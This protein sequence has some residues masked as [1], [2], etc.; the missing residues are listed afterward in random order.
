MIRVL[1]FDPAGKK[2][3]IAGIQFLADALE[4]SSQKLSLY[5]AHLLEAPESF[6]GSQRTQ[7]MAHASAAIVSLDQP[8]VIVSEEPWGLG[9]SKK[10]L[11]QLIGAIKAETWREIEWQGVSEARRAVIGDSWGGSDKRVTSEWLLEYPW[12]ISSKRIIKKLFDDAN[13]ATDDGYDILDA[14]L[15]GLCYLIVNRGLSPKT[16]EKKVRIKI[17]KNKTLNPK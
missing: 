6:N 4:A 15:H 7:Y 13:P 2:F 17:K 16:K 5:M 14:I 3:G 12:D 9:Y 11:T 8:N 1:A 10:T